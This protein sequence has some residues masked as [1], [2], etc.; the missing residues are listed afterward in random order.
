MTYPP[1]QFG[2]YQLIER[3]AVGGIAEI[4]HARVGPKGHVQDVAIKRL[5]PQITANAEALG[6]VVK[7]AKLVCKLAHPNIVQVHE[8]GEVHGQYYIAMDLIDGMDAWQLWRTLA[9]RQQRLPEVLALHIV[10][11]VL[12]ALDYAHRATDDGGRP[13]GVVHRDIA[14]SNILISASGQVKV[15]DFG[16]ALAQQ[17]TTVMS[18]ALRG[19]L[20]YMSPEQVAGTRIDQRSDIFSAGVVL[21]ELLLGR[22]LFAGKSVFDTMTKVRRADLEV[23]DRKQRLIQRE[24]VRILRKALEREPDNRYQTAQHLAADLGEYILQRRLRIAPATLAEFLADHVKPY[25]VDKPQGDLLPQ[26]PATFGDPEQTLPPAV[27]IGQPMHS[28]AAVVAGLTPPI[29]AGVQPRPTLAPPNPLAVLTASTR[30]ASSWAPEPSLEPAATRAAPELTDSGTLVGY[31]METRATETR[32]TETKATEVYVA[33]SRIAAGAAPSEEAGLYGGLPVFSLEDPDGAVELDLDTVRV[34][35]PPEHLEVA[36]EDT[37]RA[38]TAAAR[39][40]TAGHE[41]VLDEVTPPPALAPDPVALE[42]ARGVA[43]ERAGQEADLDQLD[44]LDALPG[45][46]VGEAGLGDMERARVLASGFTPV[47]ELPQEAHERGD[48]SSRT[49]T[50]VLFRLYIAAENGTLVLRGPRRSAAV[51]DLPARV[52]ARARAGASD[53][54]EEGWLSCQIHIEEGQ[55]HLLCAER[56]EDEFLRYVIGRNIVAPEQVEAAAAIDPQRPLAVLVGSGVLGPLQFS[57]QV[58]SFV[59]ERVVC[60]LGW[61]EGQYAFYRDRA[62]NAE[63]LPS[64]MST[65]ELIARGVNG[66]DHAS[67]EPYFSR[68]R[69]CQIGPSRSPLAGIERLEPNP[70]LLEVFSRL[71]PLQPLPELLEGCAGLGDPLRVQQ[72]LYL[73]LECQLAEAR[74]EPLAD[75]ERGWRSLVTAPGLLAGPI[76]L[77]LDSTVRGTLSEHPLAWLL[78]QAAHSSVTGTLKLTRGAERKVVHILEGRPIYVD[79][80]LRNEALGAYL[81]SRGVIDKEQLAEALGEAWDSTDRLGE[82]LVRMGFVDEAAIREALIV[83][84]HIKLVSALSWADGAFIFTPRD[85]LGADSGYSAEPVGLVLRV[86]RDHI[87]VED[88]TPAMAPFLNL[89]VQLSSAGEHFRGRID[90]VFGVEVVQRLTS[91]TRLADLIQE[92]VEATRLLGLTKALRVAGLA[93]FVPNA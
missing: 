33:Q 53:R 23:L 12:K 2:R 59:T 20:G 22:R 32:A 26:P 75:E 52:Q 16:I 34:S 18:G 62:P 68:L 67:L 17:E 74:T 61:T 70:L 69:S 1:S 49:V 19:K 87:G 78:V 58:G 65:L 37:V 10:S 80:N 29:V 28:M 83:Q 88:P 92:E 41:L 3:I 60:A 7:E 48:L 73:L 45:L 82:I 27:G 21:A 4:F 64:G 35:G 79:S 6:I 8:I 63:F 51:E 81:V 72:A 31:R 47:P 24:V 40:K 84:L 90:K 54:D 57:R 46:G 86:L 55:A 71:E 44:Q 5:L 77:D 25:V 76:H 13:L 56:S 42:P 43:A 93:E 9:N 30:S 85:D 50:E 36:F 89:G 14:P 66:F 11:E 91:G 38:S 39:L 15:S